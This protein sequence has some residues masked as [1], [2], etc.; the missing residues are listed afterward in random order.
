MA[1]IYDK[2]I[3]FLK[4]PSKWPD[5]GRGFMY[6]KRYDNR[7]GV[8]FRL[9]DGCFMITSRHNEPRFAQQFSTF[10][11]VLKAGWRLV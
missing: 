5:N 6:V 4:S 9:Q 8:C 2:A 1:T 11:D 7:C 10:A 3:E